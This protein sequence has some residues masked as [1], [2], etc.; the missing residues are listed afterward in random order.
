MPPRPIGM[1]DP[2]DGLASHPRAVPTCSEIPMIYLCDDFLAGCLRDG[3]PVE[4]AEE[5]P[6][7]GGGFAAFCFCRSHAAA[8]ARTSYETAWL[9]PIS[10]TPDDRSVSPA[11]PRTAGSVVPRLA[12][13]SG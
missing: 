9:R 5:G 2:A 6:K 7:G 11:A 3:V 12:S 8:F 13:T 10:Q 1:G 4:V